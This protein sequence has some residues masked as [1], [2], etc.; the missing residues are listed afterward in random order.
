MIAPADEAERIDWLRLIRSENVGPDTFHNLVQRFG[1][2]ARALDALPDL[3]AAGGLRRPIAVA[4][5]ADIDRELAAAERIG[6][7]FVFLGTASYP[8][9]LAE[10]GAPPPVL[11]VRGDLAIARRPTVAI[12]G[13]RQASAAGRTLSRTFAEAFGAAGCTVASGLA[14]GID[15]EAHKAS[16][17]TGTVAVLAGGVDRPSPEE[18]VDLC[19]QIADEGAVIS[20]M[21]LSTEPFARLFVRRNRLIAGLALGTVVIEAAARS[22]SL[23]TANFAA[24]A[25]R[26]VFAVPGSPLDPRAAGCLQLLKEGAMMAT[27]PRDVLDMLPRSAEPM[28]PGFAEPAPVAAAV[29]A[30]AV[31]VV[32]A[33]LSLTPMPVDALVRTTGL[34]AADVLAALVELELAGA[35]EREPNGMVRIALRER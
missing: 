4:S 12:V 16:L 8:P 6:A 21:P 14:L 27:E 28:L 10:I 34:A 26:E 15:T 29:P 33:A 9:L 25:G 5:D 7:H 23:H 32:R 35:A 17:A 18:N 2:A 30:D 31:G 20:E 13:A 24:A 11:V 22:G 3:A 1:S 19:A